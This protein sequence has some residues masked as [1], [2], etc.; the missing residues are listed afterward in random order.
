MGLVCDEFGAHMLAAV[1]ALV[2]SSKSHITFISTLR[3]SFRSGV[4]RVH[5]QLLVWTESTHNYQLFIINY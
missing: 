3:M 1:A 4:D 2:P 5:P